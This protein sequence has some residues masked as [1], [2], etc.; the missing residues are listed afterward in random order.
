MAG[1]EEILAEEIK[2]LGANKVEILNRAVKAQATTKT[3]Y[4]INLCSYFALRVLIPIRFDTIHNE[5]QLYYSVKRIDW[6]QFISPDQTIAVRSAV[7]SKYFTNSHYVELK[8]KDA[9]VDQFTSRFGKRPD[10]DLDE[11]DLSVNIH[12][13][14]NSLTIS[15][16]SSGD[17]LHKRGYR[18]S[19]TV[20]PIN[21]VTAAGLIKLSGWNYYDKFI[22]PMCGSGTFL[23]E[24][25][26]QKFN[27]PPQH[28]DSNFSFKE[29]NDFDEEIWETVIAEA[30]ENQLSDDSFKVYGSDMNAKAVESAEYNLAEAGLLKYAELKVKDFHAYPETKNAHLIFNP[31][32][33][34][35]IESDDIMEEYKKIGDT[36][37]QKFISSQAWIISGNIDALKR[38]GLRPSRKLTMMN[39]PIESKFYKFEMYAG[40]K[41]AKYNK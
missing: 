3:I 17:S 26:L 1:M 18:I 32:Y 6:T 37:K 34:M 25:I 36:L 38:V 7:K 22:D 30:M 31:P 2:K 41:K 19:S 39:G 24:A 10:V 28:I 14:K 20:A 15:L 8:T 12:I 21:E 35:R 16:D 5:D 33:D 13:F 4:K 9:I 23:A 27:M 29:W 40:S 11:P